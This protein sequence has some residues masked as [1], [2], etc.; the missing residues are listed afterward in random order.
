M[1]KYINYQAASNYTTQL[2]SGTQLLNNNKAFIN[3]LATSVLVDEVEPS[4]YNSGSQNESFNVKFQMS[5]KLT[6]SSG[7]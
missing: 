7:D 4:S 2:A 6:C 3:K 5:T 1:F